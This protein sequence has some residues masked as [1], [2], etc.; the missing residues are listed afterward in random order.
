MRDLPAVL[1]LTQPTAPDVPAQEARWA[2]QLPLAWSSFAHRVID[3][4]VQA[5]VRRLHLVAA[6]SV[7]A[8]REQVGEGTRWG[9]E[10][11]WH[12]VK[13]PAHLGGAL[14]AILPNH[15]ETVLLGQAHQW[16]HEQALQRLLAAEGDAIAVTGPGE[17]LGWAVLRA[18]CLATL[19]R[20]LVFSD[21]SRHLGRD[22]KLART[23]VPAHQWAQAGRAAALLATQA[24]ALHPQT[25]VQAPARWIRRPWGLLS[26]EAHVH[27]LAQIHGPAL[28][29]PGCMVMRSAVLG[30]NVVL[31]QDVLVGPGAHLNQALCLPNTYISGDVQLN[32]VVVQGA[33]VHHATWRLSQTLSARDAILSP[34]HAGSSGA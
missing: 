19:P 30:R 4:C 28:V 18:E 1:F 31:T 9:V 24:G 10:L 33:Q 21:L 7:P 20:R 25:W 12:T 22:A 16:L 29:G 17:E 23:R 5:G 15:P 32:K 2:C 3:S 11:T 13:D 14:D 6:S 26:P 34:L 8:L 27:P